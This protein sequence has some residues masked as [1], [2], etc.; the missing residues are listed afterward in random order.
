[1]I[2]GRGYYHEGTEDCDEDDDEESKSYDNRYDG[3]DE[4]EQSYKLPT[5]P[6]VESFIAKQTVDSVMENVFSSHR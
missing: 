3:E 2:E 6:S 1:M 4:E 5:V